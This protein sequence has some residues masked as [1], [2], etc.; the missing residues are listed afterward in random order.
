M[1]DLMLDVESGFLAVDMFVPLS[2]ASLSHYAVINYMYTRSDE[3]HTD[4]GIGPKSAES[5]GYFSDFSRSSP[6]HSFLTSTL[7]FV[8]LPRRLST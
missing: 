1:L 8:P 2:K 5:L 4:C 7:S 6:S 3:R